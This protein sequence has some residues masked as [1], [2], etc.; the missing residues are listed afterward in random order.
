MGWLRDVT[1]LVLSRTQ[2]TAR[3]AD[4][5]QAAVIIMEINM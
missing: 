3:R 4:P 2:V 5:G 1:D